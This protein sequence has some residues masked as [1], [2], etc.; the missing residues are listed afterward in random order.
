MHQPGWFKKLSVLPAE[1]SELVLDDFD[2]PMAGGFSNVIEGNANVRNTVELP[3]HLSSLET[4]LPFYKE[5]LDHGVVPPELRTL[6]LQNGLALFIF[7]GSSQPRLV[8][9][10]LPKSLE[11]LELDSVGAV[12]VLPKSM[13]HLKSLKID[14]SGLEGFENLP[15]SLED[16]YLNH[17]GQIQI[18]SFPP[19]LGRLSSIQTIQ[20]QLIFATFQLLSA[21]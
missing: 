13:P 20:R 3:A 4:Q 11:T 2:L 21:N 17:P 7:K 18:R 16:L 9:P 19:Q 6:K 12:V 8:L 1:L 15:N 5:I 14:Q 10:D